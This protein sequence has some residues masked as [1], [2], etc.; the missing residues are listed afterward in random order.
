MFYQKAE[1]PPCVTGC[2]CSLTPEAT[3][4][5][6]MSKEW[7][8]VDKTTSGPQVQNSKTKQHF[9]ILCQFVDNKRVGAK[10][11]KKKEKQARLK[12]SLFIPGLLFTKEFIGKQSTL[13]M[14]M[15]GKKLLVL[16]SQSR[17]RRFSDTEIKCVPVRLKQKPHQFLH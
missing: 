14:F 12:E 10:A 1:I 11:C 5:A 15:D 2:G 7:H 13:S 3:L 17:R 4:M 8:K 6:L 16:C 9:F